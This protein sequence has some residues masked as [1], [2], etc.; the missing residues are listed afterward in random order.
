MSVKTKITEAP[1]FRRRFPRRQF[2]RSVGLLEGGKYTMEYGVEIGEGGL[3][4]ESERKLRVGTHV[5]LNLYINSGNFVSVT[6]E[7]L[8]L[9]PDAERQPGMAHGAFGIKFNNLAFENKRMIR[10][11][12]AEKTLDE[13]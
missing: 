13:T 7:V 3:L 8:Y 6:G 12:I 2:L 10:D 9:L 4:L 5:V 11:Y 1:A